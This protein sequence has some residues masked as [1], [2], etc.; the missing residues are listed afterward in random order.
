MN[1]NIN[2]RCPGDGLL[3]TATIDVFT[4]YYYYYHRRRIKYTNGKVMKRSRGNDSEHSLLL[5]CCSYARCCFVNVCYT[6]HVQERRP[7]RS[8]RIC[9]WPLGFFSLH[10]I[11]NARTRTY[12]YIYGKKDKNTFFFSH[13]IVRDHQK[14]MMI[15]IQTTGID[16]P[17]STPHNTMYRLRILVRRY[18]YIE[19]VLV[20][21][22]KIY[23]HRFDPTLSGAPRYT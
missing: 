8:I 10:F 22:Y 19:C 18:F 1:N 17:S 9:S 7:S 6:T 15:D 14:I 21:R 3:R 12:L 20:C 2:T 13:I 11:H 5:Q 16:V 23:L 4:Y